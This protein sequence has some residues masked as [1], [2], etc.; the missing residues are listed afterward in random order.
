MIP[1]R[2]INEE[3][4]ADRV[5]P[6]QMDALWSQGWRRFGNYF[7]RYN[8]WPLERSFDL[9]IPL[10]LATAD[11][12][13]SKSQRRVLRKNEDVTWDIQ[14]AALAD[15]VCE[16]FA[17]HKA[18]FKDNVP[19]SLADFL[20][21]DPSQAP[22]EC[23]MFRCLAE[24]RLVA[25]SFLDVGAHAVSSVYAVFDPDESR[26]SPGILTMLKEIEWSRTN[27]KTLQYPGYATLGPSH[28]DY[29]K[30]F[31]PLQGYDWMND[32]WLPLDGV[33][34]AMSGNEDATPE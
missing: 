3:F 20:G 29:K 27:G 34:G 21:H 33:V 17:R 9:I 31:H 8:L 5:T 15:D 30:Q 6:E 12:Q 10:R 14:P 7:F 24:G 18:R 16:L 4:T 11:F 23:L 22:C 19:G 28:Y 2:W 13:P 1:Q 32:E 26:R 25:A